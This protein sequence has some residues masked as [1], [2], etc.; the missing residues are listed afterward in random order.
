MF[1]AGGRP[2]LSLVRHYRV[3]NLLPDPAMTLLNACLKF[4]SSM[5][6]SA[7][8]SHKSDDNASCI[9]VQLFL[10]RAYFLDV[11]LEMKL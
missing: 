10:C 6:D 1:L 9:K 8:L 3:C 4:V 7:C 11:A 2:S 5:I